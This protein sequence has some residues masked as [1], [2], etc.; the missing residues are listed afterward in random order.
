MGRKSKQWGKLKMEPPEG[1]ILRDN[2]K[3]SQPKSLSEIWRWAKLP[4]N[5]KATSFFDMDRTPQA[6]DSEF[7]NVWMLREEMHLSDGICLIRCQGLSLMLAELRSEM[8]NYATVNPFL[9]GEV[10]VDIDLLWKVFPANLGYVLST[11]SERCM[12]N[13]KHFFPIY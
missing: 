10:L 12:L 11:L 5:W 7:Y 4:G 3:S 13:Q 2:K 1:R 8:K 9:P 6:G